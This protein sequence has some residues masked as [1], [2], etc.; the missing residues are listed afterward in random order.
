MVLLNF[1]SMSTATRKEY[2]RKTPTFEEIKTKA[3]KLRE[4]LRH[5]LHSKR[6]CAGQIAY[7]NARKGATI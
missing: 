1:T 7:E 6:F 4:I 5:P 3:Q 2:K